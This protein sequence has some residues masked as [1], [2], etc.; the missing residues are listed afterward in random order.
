MHRSPHHRKA[1]RDKKRVMVYLTP[2]QHH[3]LRVRA[4]EL[5]LSMSDLIGR[6]LDSTLVEST[7]IITSPGGT[8]REP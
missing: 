2:E 1:A 4:A 7:L 8:R 5:D 3:K 6:W